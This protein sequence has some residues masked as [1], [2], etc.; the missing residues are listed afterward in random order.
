MKCT[1]LHVDMDAF[2]AS[3]E[4]RDKPPYRGKPVIVGA[5]PRKGRGR[6]VVAA[7]SYEARRLGIHSAMPISRAFQLCPQGVYLRS[8]FRKYGE[9]SNQ[10]REIF[11]SFADHIEP[12][13]ID[14]AFLDVSK[15]VSGEAEARELARRLKKRTTDQLPIDCLCGCGSQQARCQD[16]SGTAQT[17]RIA[18][19]RSGGGAAVSGSLTHFIPL[20]C[21]PED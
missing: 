20:W 11:S 16:R 3:I 2:Y 12:L 15:E 7:C 21:G 18:R 10:I 14:E 19:G 5:D 4:Q 6:G 9:I 13:S 8:D 17:R 1:I